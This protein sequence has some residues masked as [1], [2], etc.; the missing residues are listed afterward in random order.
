[1]LQSDCED[2][3]IGLISGISS[4]I[5]SDYHFTFEKLPAEIINTGR[6]TF[7]GRSRNRRI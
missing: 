6:G 5:E 1:M 7:A 4:L 3:G 2:D